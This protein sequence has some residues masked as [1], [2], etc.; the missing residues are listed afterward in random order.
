MSLTATDLVVEDGTGLF[1]AN[2]YID[3]DEATEYHRL[4][5][6]DLWAD[7]DVSDQCVALIRAT[8]YI[9]ER[10]VFKSII[11]DD[12]DPQSLQFPRFELYDRNGTDVSETVPVEISNATCEYA[13]QV[14]G[15]GTGNVSL[16]TTPDQSDPRSTSY[17]REKVG[18]L[19]TEVHY[20]TGRGL[21]VTKT[22]PTA[23]RIVLRSTFLRSTGGGVIR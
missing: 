19:E 2:T 17:S 4:R 15:D 22:Y 13:L 7:A 23:D 6:N 8:Q 1:D 11:F 10:W 16:S 14:L 9:D 21:Q 3:L 5:G 12:T 18:S 20:D